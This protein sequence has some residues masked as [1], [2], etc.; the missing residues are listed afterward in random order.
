L[1]LSGRSNKN[2]DRTRKRKNVAELFS[3]KKDPLPRVKMLNEKN[4]ISS[5]L[6]R[7]LSFPRIP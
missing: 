4:G 1:T 3:F 5:P 2:K 6:E 7:N